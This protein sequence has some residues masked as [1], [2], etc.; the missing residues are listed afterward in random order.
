MS[1]PRISIILPC[2]DAEAYI[3][4][5][6]DSIQSQSLTDFELLCIDDGSR[7]ATRERIAQRAA[8]DSR[9]RLLH[10]P[11]RGIVDA[12]NHGL[13]MA[14]G[15]WIA[16]MDAD[17]RMH[18]QRL[19]RQLAWLQAHPYLELIGSRVRIVSEGSRSTG[20]QEYERWINQ[21]V[22]PGA[23]ADERYLE[24]PLP[25]PTWLASRRFFERHGPYR[26]GPFPEDYELILRALAHG[27]RLGKHPHVLLDWH[28]R[29]SRTSRTDPRCARAAFDRLR[30]AYLARDPRLH[31]NRPLAFWGAGRA[32]RKRL[33]PLRVQ[34]I[35][36]SRW[37]DIDPRKLGNRI[38]GAPVCPPES[39][40]RGPRPF[41][42]VLVAR[43]GARQ[44]IAGWLNRHGFR[45]GQDWLA[46]G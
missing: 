46:V 5:C 14:R 39:L 29:Q 1:V 30:Q 19:A 24:C 28:D 11:G 27:A 23:I 43:H 44:Q 15:R 26:K 45:R 34:G 37:I 31:T 8:R 7:D 13:A 6:L 18:P 35:Q 21:C 42:L 25:H 20:L 10:N 32:T 17:D 22:H 2:R 40:C 33:R 41:V 3:A 4:P 16:R 9:I 36:P 12:L 38:E